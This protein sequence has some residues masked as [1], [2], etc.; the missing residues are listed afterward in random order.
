MD[1]Q[2][3]G[4]EFFSQENFLPEQS[5][6]NIS[7]IEGSVSLEA[8]TG[9][10]LNNNL[11]TSLSTL[12]TQS[13]FQETHIE[14]LH[15]FKLFQDLP[16]EIFPEHSLLKYFNNNF[17]NAIGS[18]FLQ[19]LVESP[20][21]A[22][23]GGS[24]YIRLNHN[25][26]ASLNGLGGRDT[27]IGKKGNDLLLGEA[28]NDLIRGDSGYLTANNRK[29]GDDILIGGAGDDSLNGKGGND[30][31]TGDEGEDRIW[32]D[33]GDDVIYGGLGDDVLTGDNHSGAT[34]NDIFVLNI[35]EGTDT[36]TDF[37]QGNDGLLLLSSLQFSDIELDFIGPDTHI[38]HEGKIFAIVEGIADLTESDFVFTSPEKEL[39]NNSLIEFRTDNLIEEPKFIPAN[40]SIYHD[41]ENYWVFYADEGKLLYHFGES[42]ENLNEAG[43]D[44]DL[45]QDLFVQNNTPDSKNFAFIFG[46]Y[47]NKTYAWANTLHDNGN[48]TYAWKLHRWELTDSG[49][50]SIESFT[51]S[52]AEGKFFNHN[53]MTA[54]YT[55]NGEVERLFYSVARYG[56]PKHRFT[57]NR[58]IEPNLTD[59]VAELA[60]R[61]TD[62]Y[63]GEVSHTLPLTD[64]YLHVQLSAGDKKS[65]DKLLPHGKAIEFLKT[66]AGEP[67]SQEI[68]VSRPGRGNFQDMNYADEASHTG[69]VVLSQLDNL[70]IYAAYVTNADTTYGNYGH[71]VLRQRGPGQNDTWSNLG[72]NL[73]DSFV[74]H[75]AL[76]NN[77]DQLMLFWIEDENNDWGS[78]IKYRQYD[79]ASEEFGPIETLIDVGEDYRIKR[80][81]TSWRSETPIVLFEA[82][83]RLTPST[84]FISAG[85]TTYID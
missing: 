6:A 50:G 22:G 56:G 44:V 32:G 66:D 43:L 67:W 53:I 23:T 11:Q 70:S 9:Q 42:L 40:Q 46:T 80:M 49:L 25:R 36:I 18:D 51:A 82:E 73:T 20:D 31:I 38:S 34:G 47:Q 45:E 27:L 7:S 81:T 57:K 52:E 69:Q 30:W 8:R 39:R 33:Y 71:V 65:E 12:A 17:G 55:A 74:R 10:Q 76:T 84:Y 77:G 61:P 68:D 64:G 1:S 19:N 60:V 21:K 72:T 28:G 75:V 13:S 59:D 26:D 58:S 78:T 2:V 14:P 4:F 41:G 48:N 83:D 54:Q 35:G 62:I 24:D 85:Q 63:L 79:P 3:I 5:L 15:S 16:N 29:G 37:T